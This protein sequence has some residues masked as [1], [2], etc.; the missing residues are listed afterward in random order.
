M[1]NFQINL[2]VDFYLSTN[3]S[4]RRIDRTIQALGEGVVRNLLG[5]ALFLMGAERKMIATHLSIIPVNE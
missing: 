3:K 5:F 1:S 2:I 4:R